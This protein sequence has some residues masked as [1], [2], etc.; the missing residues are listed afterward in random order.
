[1]RF[2]ILFSLFV[3]LPRLGLSQDPISEKSQINGSFETNLQSY[4]EDESIG[5]ES[6]DEVILNNAY[7][8]IIYRKNNFSVI[9]FEYFITTSILY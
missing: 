3:I 7:L 2:K 6:A 8:N 1:M 5:A 4:L 9:K